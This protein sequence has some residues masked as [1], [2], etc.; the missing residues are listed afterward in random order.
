MNVT[1]PQSCDVVIAGGGI[2]GAACALAC[3]QAGLRVALVERE[4]SR[5]RR[6]RRGHGTHCGARRL[7]GAVRPHPPLAGVVASLQ[8]DLARS[9]EYE[10]PG[11]L[12]VAADDE[13]MAEAARKHA[14]L[15]RARG[16]QRTALQPRA[17]R[18]GTQSAPGP[19]RRIAR[20][21][22]TRSFIRPSLRLSGAAGAVAGRRR[23]ARL[24][25]YAFG[26]WR[27]TARRRHTLRAPRLVNAAR[28]RRPVLHAGT[29]AQKTQR[30]SGHYRPLSRLSSPSTRRTR[31]PEECPL[32]DHRLGCLQR[33]A[34]AA[35]A[36]CSSAR[37]ASTAT[38]TPLSIRRCWAA[39]LQRAI[40]LS[41]FARL[42]STSCACGPAFAPPRPTSC[43]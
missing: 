34:A 1:A 27:S 9:A 24:G 43:R 15:A 35:P 40:A 8:R 3:A 4:H 10:T 38:K 11:T 26:R 23:A 29:A 6:H 14:Y 25:D 32:A 16:S 17:G 33:A 41:A 36:R 31:L 39:M 7:R 12:W 18:D 19:G 37:R 20:C 2:V 42:R 5:R 30:A 22:M 13:E 28:R 21:G